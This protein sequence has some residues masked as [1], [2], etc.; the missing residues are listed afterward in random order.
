[1]VNI[2]ISRLSSF[3]ICRALIDRGSTA[4]QKRPYVT[5]NQEVIQ[6]MIILLVN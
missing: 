2:Y 6:E 4:Q 1:M 3:K 5:L